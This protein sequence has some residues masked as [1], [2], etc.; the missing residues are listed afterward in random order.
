[1]IKAEYSI[2][3]EDS[4]MEDKPLNDS[5]VWLPGPPGITGCF[6]RPYTYMPAPPWWQIVVG[7]IAKL[8]FNAFLINNVGFLFRIKLSGRRYHSN[9]ALA[10][11]FLNWR[12]N[13]HGWIAPFVDGAHWPVVMFMLVL[14]MMSYMMFVALNL[15]F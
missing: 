13:L 4:I 14:C 12:A 1:M 9:L 3:T 8:A 5:S 7:L 10:H 11:A 15:A 6:G 2:H